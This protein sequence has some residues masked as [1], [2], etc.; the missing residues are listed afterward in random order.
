MKD[1]SHS[2]AL[3]QSTSQEEVNGHKL[4]GR[5]REMQCQGDHKRSFPSDVA[6]YEYTPKEQSPVAP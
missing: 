1:S 3:P 5:S 4:A 6:R 2:A